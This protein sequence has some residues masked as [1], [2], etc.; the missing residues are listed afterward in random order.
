MFTFSFPFLFGATILFLIPHPHFSLPFLFSHITLLVTPSLCLLFSSTPSSTFTCFSLK[1][2]AANDGGD[3]SAHSHSERWWWSVRSQTRQIANGGGS[4]D[5]ANGG[6]SGP[7]PVT[8]TA[9]DGG[10]PSRSAQV[11]GG[12]ASK[13]QLESSLLP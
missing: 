7:D 13:Q 3:L 5:T 12:G 8:D 10:A 4:T 9:D 1:A 11:R 6:G 2:N